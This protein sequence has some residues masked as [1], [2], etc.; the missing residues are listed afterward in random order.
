MFLPLSGGSG[1]L[2][3]ARA[4][5]GGLGLDLSPIVAI[6]VLSIAHQLVQSGL[7]AL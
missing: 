1:D 6:I 2:I 5:P 3:G 7:D 4:R